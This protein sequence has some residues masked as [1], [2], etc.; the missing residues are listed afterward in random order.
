MRAL[1]RGCGWECEGTS[2]QKV[3][4]QVALDSRGAVWASGGV[5]VRCPKG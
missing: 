4:S 1:R 2:W 5:R 3:K